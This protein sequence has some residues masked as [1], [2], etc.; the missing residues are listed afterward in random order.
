MDAR[1]RLL[2]RVRDHLRKLHYSF[3]TEQQYLF[4]IRRFILFH[5]ERHPSAMGRVGSRHFLTAPGRR[6]ARVSTA[7]QNQAL[8]A[9][10]FLYQKVLQVELPWLD[11]I[12]R[13]KQSR[14]LRV[15]LTSTEVRAVLAHLERRVLARPAI[16]SMA[17]GLRLSE[18]LQL[19]V[20]D[21]QLRI[22]PARDRAQHRGR[23]G[24][25]D[26]PARD[27]ARPLQLTSRIVKLRH[28]A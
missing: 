17:R 3:R 4:W 2:D 10:L 8:A 19:R 7:T 20:K 25:I 22:P 9:F 1:P 12:V 23:K 5:G 15:V 21:I 18:A 27:P 11:G 13:A 14:Y 28:E 16:C 24:S 6:L 26:D